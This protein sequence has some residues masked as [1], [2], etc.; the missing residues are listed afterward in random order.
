MDAPDMDDTDALLTACAATLPEPLLELIF[1][2]W[3][4]QSV[5]ENPY[6][7]EAAQ[8][9]T[10]VFVREPYKV[11]DTVMLPERHVY[12]YNG[13]VVAM[14]DIY[15]ETDAPTEIDTFVVQSPSLSI[16]IGNDKR[17]NSYWEKTLAEDTLTEWRIELA[18]LIVVLHKMFPNWMT[19]ETPFAYIYHTPRTGTD[20]RVARRTTLER[21]MFY[22]MD[23]WEL[24][25]PALESVRAC[26]GRKCVVM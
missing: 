15:Y 8:K 22:P 17:N 1:K 24:P 25:A 14:I 11:E 2:K 3:V 18:T 4:R 26:I 13:G 9:A 20:I 21:L 5:L 16:T 12:A 6:I 7:P 23:E 19:R 10:C